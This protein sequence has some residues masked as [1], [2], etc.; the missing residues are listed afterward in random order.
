ML[1]AEGVL[2]V[3]RANGTSVLYVRTRRGLHLFHT[4]AMPDRVLDKYAVE[5]AVSWIEMGS[6]SRDVA[7]DLGVG[8]TTL[9]DALLA[10]GYQRLSPAELQQ[11]RFARDRRLGNRRGKLVRIGAQA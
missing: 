8:E 9:R 3:G 5:L 1:R 2:E 10:A 6:P 4:I 11:R 7:R